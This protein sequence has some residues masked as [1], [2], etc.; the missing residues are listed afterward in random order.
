MVIALR[1]PGRYRWIGFYRRLGGVICDRQQ[2]ARC[3]RDTIR[4]VMRMVRIRAR[5]LD[6]RSGVG[7]E[8]PFR[9]RRKAQSQLSD[10]QEAD[11]WQPECRWKNA[12]AAIAG[13]EWRSVAASTP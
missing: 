2:P 8:T 1:K 9:Q 11:R 3:A 12:G 4:G 5:L 7:A 13:H 6:V 10:D